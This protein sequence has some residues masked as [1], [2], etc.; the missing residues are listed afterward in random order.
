MGAIGTETLRG[1]TA[2]KI[3]TTIL[4]VGSRHGQRQLGGAG[5]ITEMISFSFSILL[6]RCRYG[7]ATYLV[8]RVHRLALSIETDSET[9][10]KKSGHQEEPEQP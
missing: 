6:E 10:Q 2:G 4:A 3:G 9:A 1:M 8:R 5:Q 7:S